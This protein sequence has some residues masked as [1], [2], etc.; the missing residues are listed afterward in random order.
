[1]GGDARLRAMRLHQVSPRGLAVAVATVLVA[2]TGAAEEEGGWHFGP[3]AKLSR[4]ASGLEFMLTGYAQED[5][6]SFQDYEDS[7]GQLP[8]LGATGE[9][10]RLR[11]GFEGQWKNV[12]FE[13]EV[14]PHDDNEHLK[15]LRAEVKLH[16]ALHVTAGRMKVLGSPEWLTSHAKIDFIERSL[17]ASALAPGRD[18]GVKLSGD[19]IEKLNYQI[20]VFA[21]DNAKD[22]GRSETTV[23]GRLEV[24][25][26][27]GLDVGVSGSQGTVKALPIQDGVSPS[28]NGFSVHAP[29]GFRLY[30]RHFVDGTRRRLGADVRYHHKAFGA[31]L[32]ALQLT[33]ERRGQS[34]IFDD[35]PT[36]VARGWSASATWLIT[37]ERK[38]H[39]IRPDHP[40]Y[41]HGIGAVEVGLRYDWLHVDDNGPDDGF[42]GAGNRARNIRP[43]GAS[44]ITGG[45]SWWPVYFARLMGNV[46]WERYDDALLAP[47]PGRSGHYVTLLGRLQLGIP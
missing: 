26:V 5:F 9:L 8:A 14:D 7:K 27:K 23:A 35:L 22:Q 4:P 28:A 16:T 2:S 3:G 44:I 32:E 29:S 36:E 31:K 17:L 13:V 41:R 18:W 6:R 45:V 19:P 43:V 34:S 30:E 42:R 21:G 40:V 1:M 10:R 39:T 15:N 11:L 37:G 33:E 20:G 24:T 46:A 47:V 38:A 12:S 25:P